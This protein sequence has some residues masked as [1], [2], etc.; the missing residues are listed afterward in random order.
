MHPGRV[1][2]LQPHLGFERGGIVHQR[3]Q[4]AEFPVGCLEQPDDLSF[5]SNI[6]LDCDRFRKRPNNPVRCRTILQ[7]VDAHR[8]PAL[9]S[10]PSRSGADT[11]AASRHDQGLQVELLSDGCQRRPE[12]AARQQARS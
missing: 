8:V 3:R 6:R 4:W 11:A 12:L 5:H 10:E 2:V 9:G 1:H 7:I